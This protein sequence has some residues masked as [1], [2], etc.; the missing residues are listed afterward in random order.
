MLAMLRNDYGCDDDNVRRTGEEV[1]QAGVD[2]DDIDAGVGGTSSTDKEICGDLTDNDGDGLIDEC[3]AGCCEGRVLIEVEDCGPA[4]DDIFLIR[5]STGES[6]TTPRGASTFI[7]KDLDPGFYTVTMHVLSA[8]DDLGTY[9][10]TVSVDGAVL[11]SKS[12]SPPQGTVESWTFEI[13]SE[14][15][16]SKYAAPIIDHAPASVMNREKRSR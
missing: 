1:A 15:T 5:L 12:G 8:P 13:Q 2:Q 16:V 11:L 14:G 6:A 9:C 3:D 4:D 10:L 7:S